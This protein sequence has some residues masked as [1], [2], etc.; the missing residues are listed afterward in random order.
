MKT[1]INELEIIRTHRQ[2][3]AGVARREGDDER[4][5]ELSAE[6]EELRK[7]IVFLRRYNEYK[8]VLKTLVGLIPD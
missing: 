1:A 7:A 5:G 2:H 4:A 8:T 3:N 6:A